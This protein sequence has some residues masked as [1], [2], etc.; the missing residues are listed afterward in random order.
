MNEPT[1]F[2]CVGLSARISVIQCR[3]NRTRPL[4][5][6]LK[7]VPTRPP[8]CLRCTQWESLDP[9][10][11]D[12]IDP[13]QQALAETLSALTPDIEY[14]R[15]G[16]KY[17]MLEYNKRAESSL[18]HKRPQA[19]VQWCHMLGFTIVDHEEFRGIRGTACLVF[20]DEVARFVRENRATDEALETGE[21][22]AADAP[23]IEKAVDGI[24]RA[25]AKARSNVPD[26]MPPLEESNIF[27]VACED[28]EHWDEEDK[29]RPSSGLLRLPE[30]KRSDNPPCSLCLYF[31]PLPTFYNGNKGVRLC[32]SGSPA[33]DFGCFEMRKEVPHESRPDQGSAFG[34]YP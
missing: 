16:I 20:N 14:G 2:D 1:M 32:W 8:A 31:R 18:R 34:G 28:E 22:Y 21:E 30:L 3:A 25:C 9:P 26:A 24:M 33:W 6:S 11:P 23:V 10:L 27:A 15:L 5:A 29:A 17:L 19:M 12:A 4:S 13:A 7:N